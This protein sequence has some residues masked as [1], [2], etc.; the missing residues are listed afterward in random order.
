MRLYKTC[1]F[2]T[3]R[4]KQTTW[5]WGVSSVICQTLRWGGQHLGAFFKKLIKN[6]WF[7]NIIWPFI[8]Y[9]NQK[10]WCNKKK[11]LNKNLWKYR[12]VW[13]TIFLKNKNKKKYFFV[14]EPR[15]SKREGG[16]HRREVSTRR[17]KKKREKKTRMFFFIFSKKTRRS[18]WPEK[19]K[20]SAAIL[21][22]KFLN[23][24]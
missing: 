17:L 2:P 18:I 23:I 9:T 19:R 16:R 8:F 15:G 24:P 22:Q 6:F 1:S 13:E 5:L 20:P 11:P 4:V 7:A 21:N 10:F 14:K 3:D 12:P